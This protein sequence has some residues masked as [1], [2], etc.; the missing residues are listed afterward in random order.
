MWG[1]LGEGV[2]AWVGARYGR[3]SEDIKHVSKGTTGLV[4]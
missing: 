1:I 3:R 2:P 4:I